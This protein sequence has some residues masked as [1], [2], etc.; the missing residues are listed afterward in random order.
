MCESIMKEKNRLYNRESVK[1]KLDLI[2]K[3][4]KDERMPIQITDVV[5]FGSYFKGNEKVHDLDIL[6]L[7]NLD[8]IYL[9]ARRE[10]RPI[11]EYDGRIDHPEVIT[12]RLL[13]R[14]L[15]GV[16]ITLEYS[17]PDFI[18]G[19]EIKD[20]QRLVKEGF[21]R[22]VIW[23]LSHEHQLNREKEHP[24]SSYIKY[25]EMKSGKSSN[26]VLKLNKLKREIGCIL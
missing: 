25:F 9:K 13:T 10:L 19:L 15:K 21:P 7:Y 12:K 1:E 23:S 8:G 22:E 3:R 2:I 14:G 26:I 16:D 5:V 11:K 6:L 20:K 4:V 18:E 17:I 24:L